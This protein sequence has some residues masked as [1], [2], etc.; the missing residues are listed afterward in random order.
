MSKTDLFWNLYLQGPLTKH[1]KLSLVRTHSTFSFEDLTKLNIKEM[2][3]YRKRTPSER[4]LIAKKLKNSSLGKRKPRR[5]IRRKPAN[6]HKPAELTVSELGTGTV[7]SPNVKSA[8]GSICEG[9][10]C[11]GISVIPGGDDDEN[12]IS[13]APPETSPPG[14]SGDNPQQQPASSSSPRPSSSSKKAS[15]KSKRSKD[16]GDS[17]RKDK[18]SSGSGSGSS[19]SRVKKLKMSK[20]GVV[21]TVTT[22][23]AS[24]KPIMGGKRVSGRVKAVSEKNRNR[25]IL[26]TNEEH[27]GTLGDTIF[28]LLGLRMSLTGE[29]D[30]LPGFE[31]ATLSLGV[32]KN[33]SSFGT[34]PLLLHCFFDMTAHKFE[35]YT[36]IYNFMYRQQSKERRTISDSTVDGL[37]HVPDF[38]VSGHG[39]S[40]RNERP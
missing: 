24:N 29:E 25:F 6:V 19:G 36:C 14:S 37:C 35:T 18:S 5:A 26:E 34:L 8:A 9:S 20:S 3:Y 16:S 38:V 17:K 4:E 15:H 22:S 12:V 1:Q 11:G 31:D 13:S 23:G 30:K 39:V 2:T 40:R 27:Q 28:N 21:T 32:I 10:I 33:S 7:G